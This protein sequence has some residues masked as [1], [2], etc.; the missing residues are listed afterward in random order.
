MLPAPFSTTTAAAATN[1]ARGLARVRGKD[2]AGQRSRI[3]RQQVQGIG[4]DHQRL[5]T[6]QHPRKQ[7]ARPFVLAQA[8]PDRHHRGPVQQRRQRIAVFQRMGHRL[9]QARQ[10]GADG[11]APGT[12]AQQAGAG[13]KCCLGRHRDGATAAMVAANAQHVPGFAFVGI[14][15]AGWQQ[16]L[17]TVAG[18]AL[19][20]GL[21][22]VPGLIRQ[23]E[24]R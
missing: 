9:R 19:R 2:G 10:Q 5:A 1:Q 20:A 17:Q 13:T 22:A 16:R 15:A 4:I 21:D 24:P 18:P 23:F 8:G 14:G 11:S 3:L 6:R 12:Q 7:R